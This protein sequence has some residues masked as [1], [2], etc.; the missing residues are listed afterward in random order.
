MK[1]RAHSPKGSAALLFAVILLAAA[2][3]GGDDDAGPSGSSADPTGTTR[4]AGSGGTA[5]PGGIEDQ[6]FS[7]GE[8]FWHT[9]FRVEITH[10]EIVST[11]AALTRTVTT[12]LTLSATFEN[13][14]LDPGYF[15]PQLAIV[16]SNNSYAESFQ[17]DIPDVPGGLT[18]RGT[19]TFRIDEDFDLASAELLV[20]RPDENQARVPLGGAGEAI[21]LEPSEPAIAGTLTMELVDLTFTS[22]TLAYDDPNRHREADNGKQYLTLNFD[23]VSRKGGNWQIFG[24]NFALVGPDGIAITP[25]RIEIGSLPGSDEGVLTADRYVQFLVD[26]MVTGDFTLRLTPG[27]WFIGDDG[28]LRLLAVIANKR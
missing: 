9:G 24:D 13:I 2:C 5:A 15:G 11:E 7:V 8:Q 18:S 20:G 25:S 1:S 3:G 17:S 22:A 23:A 28:V 21:R 26:E 19:L 14:G 4:P 27:Q 6:T 10:G 16:T 12:T